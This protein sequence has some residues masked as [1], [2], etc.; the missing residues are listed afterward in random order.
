MHT[1]TFDNGM[2]FAKHEEVANTLECETYFVKPYHSWKGGQNE[3]ANG[4]LGQ[5]FPKTMGLL[6]VTT[7]Q[8]LEAVHK[9]NSRPRKCLE[10]RTHY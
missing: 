10:F 7:Q 4:L 3:N 1:L 6:D 9:P 2:E 8:V 5:Y